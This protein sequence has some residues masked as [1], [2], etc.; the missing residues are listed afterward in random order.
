MTLCLS[1]RKDKVTLIE[2][3]ICGVQFPTPSPQP[4]RWDTYYGQRQRTI[5]GY[6]I[7]CDSPVYEDE[8]G[9]T[10]YTGPPDCNCTLPVD[11]E[12]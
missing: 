11:E 6:C 9:E 4:N 3:D 7:Y 8:E 1:S 2:W 10:I 5:K 12:D